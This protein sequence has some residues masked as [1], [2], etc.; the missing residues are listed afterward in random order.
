VPRRQ[1]HRRSFHHRAV[2]PHWPP[3]LYKGSW[4]SRPSPELIAP[5]PSFPPRSKRYTIEHQYSPLLSFVASRFCHLLPSSE[6][7]NKIP[8]LLSSSSTISCKQSRSKAPVHRA[9]LA[10]AANR[11]RTAS[12]PLPQLRWGL[13]WARCFCLYLPRDLRRPPAS[14]TTRKLTSDD[15]P[16]APPFRP[17]VLHGHPNRSQWLRLEHPWRGMIQVHRAIDPLVHRPCGPFP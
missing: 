14:H 10:T 2:S 13:S 7:E 5:T 1:H 17:P 16:R 8:D 3:P 6:E 4:P 11:R 15:P 12:S 9:S